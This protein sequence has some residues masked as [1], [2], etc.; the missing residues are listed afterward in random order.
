MKEAIEKARALIEALP[1]IRSFRRK[2]VVVKMGGS[3]MTD[4]PVLR[5]V[6][7]DLVFM[8]Q[9]GMWPVLVH[10]GG[11]RI[12]EEMKRA[13]VEPAFVEG[14]RVT[15]PEVI[16]I[17]ARVLIEEISAHICELIEQEGGKAIPMNG[18]GSSFL[19]GRKRSLPGAPGVDL[20]LVGDITSVDR[21]ACYRLADGGIIPVVAPIA[22]M[23]AAEEH[24]SPEDFE[25]S[26]GVPLLNI[27]GDSAASG[28]ARGLGAEKVVFLSNVA[29]VMRDPSDESTLISSI[30]QGE[31]VQLVSDGVI[32]GGML[33]KVRSCLEALEAGV[34]KAHIVSA[35]LP[36]ALLLEMF[37]DKGT[38]TE[39]VA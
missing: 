32:S 36:H 20:G 26:G 34:R 29:G 3:A 9:V 27:N 38:G 35:L 25:F 14:H 13:G 8:E 37:T 22:R 5:S 2:F 24:P 16:R 28:V 39:L 11:P 23:E 7:K 31:V 12:T 33:P 6:V 1:Y 30:R 15:T 21:E 17:A 18:R 10:G 4:E 19:L